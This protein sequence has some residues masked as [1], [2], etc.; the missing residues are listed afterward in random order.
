MDKQQRSFYLNVE[1]S[2]RRGEYID[3][4]GSVSYVFVFIYKLISKWDRSGFEELS[5]FLIQIS[6]LYRHEDKLY[7]YCLN[8][9]YDCL[10]GLKRYEEFLEKTEPR[11]VFGT[12]THQ[13]NLRI[14]IQKHLNI[15]AN[16]IDVLLMAGGRKTK[17]IIANE[18]L[19]R[20][21]VRSVFRQ[22]A[23][24]EGG[25][26]NVFKKFGCFNRE[27]YQHLLFAG[28]PI[29]TMPQLEF[30]IFGFYAAV[31]RKFEH[32]EKICSLSKDAENE[33]RVEIGVPQIGEG[34]VSETSLFRKLESEFVTTNV[35]QHGQPTWLGRQHFDIW[36][37][38]WKIAV[39]YHG[40]QHFEPVDFFG[41]SDAFNKTV[42]R[43]K[44]K[45]DLAKRH[46]V[47]L[48]V[49]TEDDDCND[50]VAQIREVIEKRK[51]QL[52]E[53]GLV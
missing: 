46:S 24:K 12:S 47:K 48:F 31:N 32:L 21:K 30:S 37:P 38:N 50:L 13:S 5:D 16:P 14:N 36:I 26:F 43:D 23:E 34:W 40:K 9:A 53:T 41:G 11:Q 8:W 44:R 19:Y 28:A 4:Q 2:L 42:E 49:V 51:I 52:P 45:A 7:F 39:E 17:F 18:V 29:S 15:E 1:N 27:E 3:I 22:Y 33:A 20:E 35:I 25:W 6:E 10:L